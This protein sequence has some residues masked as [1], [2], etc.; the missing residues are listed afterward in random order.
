MDVKDSK[1]RGNKS[2]V[3]DKDK[4]KSL[5]SMLNSSEEDANVA[6]ECINTLDIKSNVVPILL[7]RKHSNTKM[8]S[9]NKLCKKHIKYHKSLDID[10][11]TKNVTYN[12]IYGVFKEVK[13]TKE[14]IDMFIE[15]L[16]EFFK[17]NTMKFDF[18]KSLDIKIE[19]K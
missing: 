9:W 12:D 19:L 10:D 5:L 4:Y 14:H 8:E 6:F 2:I 16:S 1:N 11:Y 13:P 18:V 15:D 17:R 7:L 3:I